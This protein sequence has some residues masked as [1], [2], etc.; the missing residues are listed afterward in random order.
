MEMYPTQIDNGSV[1]R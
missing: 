1:V